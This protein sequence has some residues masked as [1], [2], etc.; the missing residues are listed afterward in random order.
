MKMKLND[1]KVQTQMTKAC[2]E[3][4]KSQEEEKDLRIRYHTGISPI[5]LR[6]PAPISATAW[7]STRLQNFEVVKSISANGSVKRAYTDSTLRSSLEMV[8]VDNDLLAFG[9]IS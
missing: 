7:L 1:E 2:G 9:P 8:Q 6:L 4:R 5:F 3:K